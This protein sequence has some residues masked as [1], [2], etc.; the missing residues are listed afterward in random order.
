L[1]KEALLIGLVIQKTVWGTQLYEKAVSLGVVFFDYN[2]ALDL[3]VQNNKCLGAEFWDI[4]S[5]HRNIILANDTVL[6]TGGYGQI[7]STTTCAN[8]CTGDGMGLAARAG[9]GLQDMEF[10]QFHPTAI[11]K[12]GVLITEAARSAGA[13]LLN[14]HGERF[15]SKYAPNMMELA[16]RDV[17]AR[18]ISTEVCIGNGA[19]EDKD[20]VW[21]DLRDLSLDQIKKT[22]PTV[23]ENSLHFAGVDPSIA[24]IPIGPAAHYNMGGIP[25][26][27]K[28]Q[29]VKHRE[30]EVVVD[31]LYAIGETAC[32][33]VHGAGRLGCNS[34][35]DLL[36]FAKMVGNQLNLDGNRSDHK[37]IF[38]Q[39]QPKAWNL[40][41][42]DGG[43]HDNVDKLTHDLRQLMNKNVGVF[44]S[45]LTLQTAKKGLE[46]IEDQLKNI[47][48]RDKG[49]KW[50]LE[51]QH[52]LELKNMIICAKATVIGALHRKESRGA[53]WRD[54]YTQKNNEYLAHFVWFLGDDSDTL[55]KR[56]VREGN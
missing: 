34:L 1:A 2:F 12:V 49:L 17:V 10:V 39:L 42:G 16:T 46:Q 31:G 3:I 43:N 56:C 54:D 27:N 41:F 36:V 23:Y 28:C 37:K 11:N 45:A 53:H 26:N 13:K 30:S 40:E 25:T 20:H 47:R 55:W 21:L 4:E 8:I 19:G 5:G 50:N 48:L 51:L 18:A 15:M 24:M 44:R 52:Y 6:A 14:G 32:V 9:I 7:Y 35:L 22:L 38:A 29:V 33:S